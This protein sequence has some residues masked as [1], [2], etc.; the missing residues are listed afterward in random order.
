[1][2]IYTS[3]TS[4]IKRK[5]NPSPMLPHNPSLGQQVPGGMSFPLHRRPES[6]LNLVLPLGGIQTMMCPECR[7]SESRKQ[8]LGDHY[9]KRNLDPPKSKRTNVLPGN[10]FWRHQKNCIA[11]ENNSKVF[12]CLEIKYI[13]LWQN[14]FYTFR[15]FFFYLVF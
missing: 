2:Y 4:T 5:G 1:M 3:C 11:R 15:S 10:T 7:P 12:P 8:R 13:F 9:P 6:P 14:I